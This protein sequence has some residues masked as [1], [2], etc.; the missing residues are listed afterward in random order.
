MNKKAV[1]FPQKKEIRT[2]KQV[3][4]TRYIVIGCCNDQGGTVSEKV[5]S[6]IKLEAKN[7]VSKCDEI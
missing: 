6:L 7:I 2:E 3:G 5:K 1:P 4:N